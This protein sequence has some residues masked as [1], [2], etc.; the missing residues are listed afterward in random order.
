[1]KDSVFFLGLI[2]DIT[3]RFHHL[4]STIK[5]AP[6]PAPYIAL[7]SLLWEGRGLRTIS[8]HFPGCLRTSVLWA[9]KGPGVLE[10]W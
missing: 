2:T 10:C 7:F 4:D 8:P 1:M 9:V 3:L 6:G 5:E